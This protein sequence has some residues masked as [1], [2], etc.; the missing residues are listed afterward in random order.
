MLIKDK[1]SYPVVFAKIEISNKVPTFLIYGHFDVQSADKLDGRT[2][3][4]PF[5]LERI[6]DVSIRLV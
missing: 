2:S 6:L 1:S 3:K 5:K 4:D